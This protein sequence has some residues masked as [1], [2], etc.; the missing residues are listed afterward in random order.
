MQID[1]ICHLSSAAAPIGNVFGVS[2]PI[3]GNS[4]AAAKNNIF[5]TPP[6][7]YNKV[8]E[9]TPTRSHSQ[10]TYLPSSNSETRTMELTQKQSTSP[11]L[12]SKK[13]PAMNLS[14]KMAS[15]GLKRLQ[16]KRKYSQVN[17]ENDE[18]TKLLR[19]QVAS[20]EAILSA[21]KAQAESTKMIADAVMAQT[22]AFN[23]IA[24][25]VKVIA[26][27]MLDVFQYFKED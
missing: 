18:Q 25:S 11:P 27:T 12:S 24:K 5:I 3:R 15:Q 16:G 26:K 8:A 17:T 10:Q 22:D 4:T 14:S 13:Q 9:I 23:D 1:K 21:M 7:A 19:Q 6:R 20:Q 2:L